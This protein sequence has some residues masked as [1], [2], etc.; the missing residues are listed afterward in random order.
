MTG[1]GGRGFQG[2]LEVGSMVDVMEIHCIHAW[3]CQII[4]FVSVSI[5]KIPS[6]GNE[7]DCTHKHIFSLLHISMLI[8]LES[9]VSKDKL[10]RHTHHS[11][12]APLYSA[13]QP[14]MTCF[15]TCP[16]R[17]RYQITVFTSREHI[18]CSWHSFAKAACVKEERE[19]AAFHSAS[20]GAGITQSTHRTR[21]QGEKKD[22][23]TLLGNEKGRAIHLMLIHR[24]TIDLTWMFR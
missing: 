12:R 1:G 7:N 10:H 11:H 8:L 20:S 4:I 23:S 13:R 2:S 19:A 3:N 15:E 14:A 5:K 16:T 17:P 24:G 21:T 6:P 9:A 22:S 18:G